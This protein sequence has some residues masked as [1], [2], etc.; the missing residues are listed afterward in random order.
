MSTP[1]SL[2]EATHKQLVARRPRL[3]VLPWGATEAHNQH[4]PY[5]TDA[6]EAQR[7]AQRAAELAAEQ[8]A[9]VIVLPCIPFGNNAQQQDQIAAIHLRTSTALAL[10][11]DVAWSLQRQ[12]IGRLV[13]LNAHGGNEFKPLIRDLM[14]E[15][16]LFMAQVNF[17]QMCPERVR[18]IFG[19]EGDHAGALETS[20]LLHWCPQAVHLED[21]GPGGRKPFAVSKLQQ[22]G[23]WTPRPWS[24]VHPDLGAG[25]PCGASAEKGQ[26]A[27]E[28]I[29][30]TIAELLVELAKAA[31]LP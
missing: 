2:F 8:G 26:R 23:V 16:G 12:G 4:L 9:R 25:D 22:E 30:K 19:E 10:L 20:L 24:K 5:A 13:I 6:L 1:V 21:A 27:F 31:E 29:S 15:T 28:A 18:E 3:A 17:W 7:F 11:T 14:L